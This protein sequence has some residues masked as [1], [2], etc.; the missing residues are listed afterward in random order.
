[1]LSKLRNLLR[2]EDRMM[3]FVWRNRQFGP[4]HALQMRLQG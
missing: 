2:E 1:M 4:T 3:T